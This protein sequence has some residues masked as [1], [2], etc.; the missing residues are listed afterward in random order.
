MRAKTTLLMITLFSFLMGCTSDE[1]NNQSCKGYVF[2]MS[3]AANGNEL[4]Q[5]RINSN[6]ALSLLVSIPTTGLG[7][8]SNLSSQG[9]VVLSANKK[10][11]FVANAGDHSVS[12]FSLLPNGTIALIGKYNLQGNRPIS[13]SQ[14]NNLVYVL[15]SAGASGAASIEGFSMA[16]SGV[17]NPIS[18]SFSALP[19]NVNPAQISFVHNEVLVVSERV[20]NQ[21]TT[22]TLDPTFHTPTA[23]QFITTVAPQPYGFAV[24]SAG[25]IFVT[26]ASASSSVS[27]YAVTPSG[28]ISSISSLPNAQAGAC[29][30]AINSSST[31]CYSSNAS[32]NTISSFT[33]SPSGSLTA[34]QTAIALGPG[35]SPLEIGISSNDEFLFVLAG[36]SDKLLPFKI[37][38]NSLVSI[39]T[40]P[41]DVP[42]ASYGLAVY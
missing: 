14:R 16:N 20:T 22:F 34:T 24:N 28:S 32:A 2:T 1:S 12:T 27:S 3:N 41:I 17:L 25:Q 33:I 6:G 37:S 23:T 7:T 11:V 42:V 39:E 31:I 13:I 19:S 4:L 18:N 10:I 5:Y 36:T 21:L 35:N 9:S 38:G 8:G 29:W 26:E 40:P 30:A 15:C